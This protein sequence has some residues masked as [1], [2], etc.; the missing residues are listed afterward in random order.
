MGHPLKE[1]LNSNGCNFLQS[2]NCQTNIEPNGMLKA[3]LVCCRQPVCPVEVC[4]R[5]DL[6]QSMSDLS[7]SVS[8]DNTAWNSHATPPGTPP[9]PYPSQVTQ[10]YRNCDLTDVC[11]D[12]SFAENVCVSNC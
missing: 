11:A 3:P 7:H 2:Y 8:A 1:N 5:L 9:P 12:L 6:S 10:N 4:R